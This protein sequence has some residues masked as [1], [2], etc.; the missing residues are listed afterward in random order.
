[1]TSESTQQQSSDLRGRRIWVAGHRGMVG[2][3]IVRRLAREECKILAGR[4]GE[5][6]LRRAQ[7]V[8]RGWRPSS[9]SSCFSQQPPSAAS[10]PDEI[11][12]DFIYDN[13]MI[14]A[15]I[16]NA[17]WHTRV[18]RKLL[19]LGSSCIYPR[20]AAQP[21]S[22]EALLSRRRGGFNQWYP[23]VPASGCTSR[24]TPAAR[25]RLHLR[26]ARRPISTAPETI[27]I[28]RAAT[29]LSAPPSCAASA[30]AKRPA[31]PHGRT[32][33][34]T[35]RIPAHLLGKVIRNV[36][37]CVVR[38]I[39]PAPRAGAGPGWFRRPGHVLAG[40]DDRAGAGV[41]GGVRVVRGVV[42]GLAGLPARG[43]GGGLGRR[44]GGQGRGAD[45]PGQLRAP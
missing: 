24:C 42:P 5:L 31:R 11:Q 8:R 27:S 40:R 29:W 38:A 6:D 12:A 17:A 19:F 15:N 26:H 20:D 36:S 1:M 4:A 25:L 22:E 32:A 3:A 41:P 18:R 44:R 16:I 2:S 21:M 37:W 34:R 33:G 23:S 13:L 35:R 7:D 28:S 9:P 30:Q 39:V 14:E 10:M 45:Y 43:L